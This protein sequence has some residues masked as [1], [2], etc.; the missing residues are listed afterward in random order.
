[1]EALNVAL[2]VLTA[3][4]FCVL[5][6]KLGKVERSVT[7]ICGRLERINGVPKPPPQEG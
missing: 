5:W 7:D 3:T 1:M 6:Y 4:Q 2:V